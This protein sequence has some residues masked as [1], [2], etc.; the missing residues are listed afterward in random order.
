MNRCGRAMGM[1]M[2]VLVLGG[3]VAGQE[4]RAAADKPTFTV[5]PFVVQPAVRGRV[6]VEDSWVLTERFAAE[7]SRQ[8]V[9]RLLDS[10]FLEAARERGSSANAQKLVR[11]MIGHVGETYTLQTRVVDVKTGVV[12]TQV[13]TDSTGSVDELLT[14]GLRANADALVKAWLERKAPPPDP[15]AAER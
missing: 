15:A 2:A 9:F 1:V 5:V 10:E 13:A 12:E 14:R 7:L 4:A 8:E 3:G 11:G 6:S